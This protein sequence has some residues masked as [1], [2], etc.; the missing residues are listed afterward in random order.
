MTHLHFME[1]HSDLFHAGKNHGRKLFSKA[2]MELFYNDKKAW[3]EVS[4]N[5]RVAKIP[6]S[7][8]QSWEDEHP[9]VEAVKEAL[10]ASAP[11]DTR[12][13]RSAQV[14]TPMGHV[15]DGEGHGKK[16]DRS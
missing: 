6:M 3:F 14:S 5:K 10:N 11:M 15:F 9:A 4:Y 16:N 13:I 7:A 1:L 8:V 12:R 2:G